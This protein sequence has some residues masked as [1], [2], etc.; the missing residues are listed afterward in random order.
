MANGESKESILAH[1]QEFNIVSAV[2]NKTGKPYR[3]LELVTKGGVEIR[4]FVDRR[5]M[6]DLEAEVES[7]TKKDAQ[8][9]LD[10]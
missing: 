8:F 10:K 7:Q 3:I 2:S 6:R 1:V 9:D 5:D 4:F